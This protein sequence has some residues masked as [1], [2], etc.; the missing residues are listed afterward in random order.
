MCEYLDV[1]QTTVSKVARSVKG[2]PV[3]GMGG[4]DMSGSHDA[5]PT[6]AVFTDWFGLS[7]QARQSCGARFALFSTRSRPMYRPIAVSRAL[8]KVVVSLRG[9]VDAQTLGQTLTDL[10]NDQGNLALVIDLRHTDSIDPSG[11]AVLV[12]ASHRLH[13]H[14]GQLV[15]SGPSPELCVALQSAGLTVSGRGGEEGKATKP[16]AVLGP[17]ARHE[18]GQST[19]RLGR[20]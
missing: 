14:A 1:C 8:G 18:R 20:D 9:D 10:V 13:T 5:R 17:E 3:W 4:R 15:L 7:L 2:L 11:V 12:R 16:S 19:P 6:S